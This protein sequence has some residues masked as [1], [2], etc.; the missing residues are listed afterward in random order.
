MPNEPEGHAGVYMIRN[1]IT[2]AAY[3]GA[4]EDVHGRMYWYV[5]AIRGRNDKSKPAQRIR[6]AFPSI[7]DAEFRVL[8]YVLV[9]PI[10]AYFKRDPGL[11]GKQIEAS[12]A[13]RKRLYDRETHW[14][15]TL[16]P[17]LNILKTKP[18][19]HF[20]VEVGPPATC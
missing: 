11:L 8:E 14:I 2:G 18:R 1:R 3:I 6:A 17:S 7:T 9:P 15:Q 5:C 4:S 20:A 12:I 16:K 19:P 10:T 13:G